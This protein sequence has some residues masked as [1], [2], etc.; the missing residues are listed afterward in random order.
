MINLIFFS[1]EVADLLDF[2]SVT[3][4]PSDCDCDKSSQSVCD[5]KSS[6]LSDTSECEVVSINSYYNNYNYSVFLIIHGIGWW[7]GIHG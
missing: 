2:S 3:S 5:Y 6:S 7:Y 4:C 1:A